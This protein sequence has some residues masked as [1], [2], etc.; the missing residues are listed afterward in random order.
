LALIRLPLPVSD[1]LMRRNFTYSK[2]W[3]YSAFSWG[4]SP[5]N[6]KPMDRLESM[7]VFVTV[8]E[9]GGFSAASRRLS[10]PLATVSRRVSEL[11]EQLGVSLLKR[12]TRQVTLTDSGRSYFESCRRILG[13]VDEAERTA[14]GEYQSPKGELIV[15]A[16]IVFGRLHV[17]PLVIELIGAHPELHIR[18]VL[19]DRRVSLVE[20]HVDVAVRIG[21]LSD[22]SLVATRVGNTTRVVCASPR[23]LAGRERPTRPEDLANHDCINIPILPPSNGWLLGVGGQDV[24]VPINARLV[25]TTAEAGV[26]AAVLGAGIVQAQC[27]QVSEAVRTQ[28]L[29]LLLLPFQPTRMPVNLVY[30]SKR[31]VPAKLRAFLDF[32]GPRL[33]A[34]LGRGPIV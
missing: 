29:E 9:E 26:D 21:A 23:Y 5:R 19:L 2:S 27:Y 25:V 10:K 14:A 31:L 16:P 17:L 3:N 11:E 22:S 18:L 8:V 30:P 12:T 33:R 20:E 1:E 6:G 13:D 15:T 24:S 28:K 32:A 4:I 34:R 7:S